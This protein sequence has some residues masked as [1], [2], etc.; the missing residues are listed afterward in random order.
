[1]GGKIVYKAEDKGRLTTMLLF[2]GGAVGGGQGISPLLFESNWYKER[3]ER[4]YGC[5]GGL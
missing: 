1:M 2:R 3:L 4:E 5:V